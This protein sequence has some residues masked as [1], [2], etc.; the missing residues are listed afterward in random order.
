MVVSF[1]ESLK[2]V[3]IW[4]NPGQTK[5]AEQAV[6]LFD[7][8]CNATNHK[9]LKW[10]VKHKQ[11]DVSIGR[12]Y[13]YFFFPLHASQLQLAFVVYSAVYTVLH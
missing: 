13:N 5:S 4:K 2:I 8:W 7:K 6:S 10:I 3:H 11:N 12:I 1:G 9:I